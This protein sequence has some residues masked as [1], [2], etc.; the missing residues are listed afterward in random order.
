MDKEFFTCDNGKHEFPISFIN[1]NF[2]DCVDGSDEPGTSAC[3]HMTFYCANEGYI[4]EIIPSSRV[5]DGVCD[6]SDGSD[7]WMSPSKCPNLSKEKKVQ[8]DKQLKEEGIIRREGYSEKQK[9]KKKIKQKIESSQQKIA[10]L[11]QEINEINDIIIHL[12]SFQE[13]YE[14]E[15]RTLSQEQEME[16]KSLI[17][18]SRW[19]RFKSLLGFSSSVSYEKKLNKKISSLEDKIMIL[20]DK[21]RMLEPFQ[22]SGLNL[23]N[24][25]LYLHEK[26]Y[27]WKTE[28][29]K[30]EYTFYPFNK[31]EQRDD[32]SGNVVNIGKWNKAK[33]IEGKEVYTLGQ[34]CN[35]GP[36]REV[37]IKYICHKTSKIVSVKETDFCV[38]ELI[39][40]TPAICE[41]KYDDDNNQ[42]E[43]V[44][45]Q[46][47]VI[48]NDESSDQENSKVEL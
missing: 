1:D 11:N 32:N 29:K 16:V 8:L 23:T 31:V 3:S 26:K 15:N 14:D 20:Q 36:S 34:T 37:L 4:P 19:K 25:F 27:S 46:D 22:K 35:N 40:Q 18:L 43:Q 24:D 5:N 33:I 7:E 44:S 38:Y 9:L 47:Q 48:K 42:I 28:D 10:D 39:F 41:K 45:N 2:C 12:E 30:Y 6:C 13:I 17:K 21:I